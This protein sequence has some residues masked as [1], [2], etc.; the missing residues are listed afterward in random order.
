MACFQYHG[1]DNLLNDSFAFLAK[2]FYWDAIEGFQELIYRIEFKLHHV[3]GEQLKEALCNLGKLRRGLAE[4]LFHVNRCQNALEQI[5]LCISQ[6]CHEFSKVSN[7]TQLS[8]AVAEI[9]S[10]IGMGFLTAE[11]Q[12]F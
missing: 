10:E 4:A 2:G 11:Y 3:E 6:N 5:Q 12:D 9:Y 1:S 7:I 8:L